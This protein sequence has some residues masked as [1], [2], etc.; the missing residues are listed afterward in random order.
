MFLIA[1]DASEGNVGFSFI[2]SR[3]CSLIDS[4]IASN[5]FSSAT[6]LSSTDSFTTAFK[7][8]LS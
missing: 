2:T 8:G 3:A 5:S 4:I 1:K 7:Y 6:S